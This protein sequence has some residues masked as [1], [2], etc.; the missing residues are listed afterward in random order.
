MQINTLRIIVALL[1]T[2][3]VMLYFYTD[4][5]QKNYRDSAEPAVKQILAEISTWEK[6]PLLRHLTPEAKQTIT[7]EQLNQ[8]LDRYR[9]F[10]TL[11]SVDELDFSRTASALSLFGEKRMNYSGIAH[12]STGPVNINMTLVERGGYFLVYNFALSKASED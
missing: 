1:L 9:G 2:G 5:E 8:L 10:G 6:E 4:R 11:R 12:Y 3:V 7:D